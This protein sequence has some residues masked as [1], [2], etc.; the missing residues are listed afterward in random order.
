MDVSFYSVL[1]S[2]FWSSLG[3]FVLYRCL[4]RRWF[5]RRFGI[6]MLCAL[7]LLCALRLFFPVEINGVRLIEFE[8]V[9]AS[10]YRLVGLQKTELLGMNIS[11]LQV[12]GGIWIVGTLF[13]VI[14][15]FFIC[16]QGKRSLQRL[17][18][19]A[20]RQECRIM[21]QIQEQYGHI[22]NVEVWKST[23]VN[24]PMGVGI[25]KKRIL[26]PDQNYSC[27]QLSCILCHE[28]THF[29][30][31]DIETK[32]LLQLLCCVFWWN[33]CSYLLVRE[34]DQIL[35][36][37]C[38]LAVTKAMDKMEKSI[39]LETIL[40][41]LQEGMGKRR[42]K[43]KLPAAMLIQQGKNYAVLE[44]FQIVKDTEESKHSGISCWVASVLL[45]ILLCGSY[46]FQFQA[47]FPP[48]KIER[49]LTPDDAYL[50]DNKDGTYTLIYKD[51]EKGKK[52]KNTT[53]RYLPAIQGMI[54]QGFEVKE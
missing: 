48:P 13:L 8:G 37:R 35:E 49:E 19:H 25:L 4:K 36:I 30:N 22:I 2:V 26:I 12:C 41:I 24:I 46:L 40:R 6:Q 16:F 18:E 44:R 53:F 3:V 23:G 32:L 38:D 51:K 52:S 9:F 42:P 29:R 11:A 15:W 33:P 27:E 28:Y 50:V 14:R 10:A 43:V 47:A 20:Q 17:L 54:E 5:I 7:Y 1:M 34:I 21:E 45:C 39:Y 31:H